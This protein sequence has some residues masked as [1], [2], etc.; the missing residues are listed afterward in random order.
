M[1]ALNDEIIDLDGD[2]GVTVKISDCGVFVMIQTRNRAFWQLAENCKNIK[3][4]NMSNMVSTEKGDI[5]DIDTPDGCYRYVAEHLS[6]TGADSK[7][8]SCLERLFAQ[9]H[10]IK[11]LQEKVLREKR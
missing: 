7:T 6:K 2:A 4:Y 5:F 11:E 3:D 9:S 10:K 1:V 8:Y